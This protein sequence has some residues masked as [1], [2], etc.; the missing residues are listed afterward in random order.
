M[1][2]IVLRVEKY[3]PNKQVSLAST[4]CTRS[5]FTLVVGVA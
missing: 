5:L 2:I 4:L 3:I 1:P